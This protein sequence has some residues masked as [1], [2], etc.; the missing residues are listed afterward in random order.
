MH[1]TTCHEMFECNPVKSLVILNLVEFTN[2]ALQNPIVVS[3]AFVE[4]SLLV[5][6]IKLLLKFTELISMFI[7]DVEVEGVLVSPLCTFTREE[8]MTSHEITAD[9]NAPSF[10]RVKI[11]PLYNFPVASIMSGEFPLPYRDKR[12]NA[13]D[14]LT[15]F[16]VTLE[17]TP[18]NVV[19]PL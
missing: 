6:I 12:T 7:E 19:C 9:V 16:I 17:A 18:F 2:S 11:V 3:D 14:G 13:C 15:T 10:S 4:L 8:L 1:S 5:I